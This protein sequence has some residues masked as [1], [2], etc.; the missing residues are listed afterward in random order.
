MAAEHIGVDAGGV[1]ALAIDG[2]VLRGSWTDENAQ[3]TLFSAMVQKVGVT[4][5]QVEVPAGTNEI[6]Q[7][8]SLLE[9]VPVADADKVVI[10]ADAAH[11]QRETAR[12]IKDVRGFDYFLQVKGNQLN[13]LVAVFEKVSPL[14]KGDPGHSV[15]ERGDGRV[16]VWDMWVTDAAGID[17]LCAVCA[18]CIR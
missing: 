3:F 15:T 6:T 5:A 1:L 9:A 11:T 7:V 16:N 13:L 8:E 10:T 18:A 4:I 14:L 17:F 12:H 2:K